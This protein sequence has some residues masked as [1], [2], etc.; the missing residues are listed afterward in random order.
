[1]GV[2]V[3]CVLVITV[4]SIVCRVSLG[5]RIFA[6]RC[7]GTDLPLANRFT[8]LSPSYISV[9]PGTETVPLGSRLLGSLRELHGQ[10]FRPG[11]GD[12]IHLWPSSGEPKR[13]PCWLRVWVDCA[14]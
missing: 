9:L 10:N 4:F 12:E 11:W 1:V 6:P 14:C 7:E 5:P 8:P 2:L 13:A 3:I